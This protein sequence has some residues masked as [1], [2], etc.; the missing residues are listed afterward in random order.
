MDRETISQLPEN[1]V[2]QRMRKLRL[3]AG[4]SQE[5]LSEYLNVTPNY[6]G[7]VERDAKGLSKNLAN[8][9]CDFFQV[10]YDYLYRGIGP[11]QIREEKL[12]DT[13]KKHILS[14]IGACTEDECEIIYPILKILIQ[15]RRG[16]SPLEEMQK[17]MSRRAGR[18]R[19]DWSGRT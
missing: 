1:T 16:D 4:L 13:C 14:Y 7:Q 6:Y 12:R 18:P 5:R 2:G 10:T 19:K 17:N 11:E 15:S 8:A 9:M 3:T